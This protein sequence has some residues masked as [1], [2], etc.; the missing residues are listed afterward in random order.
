MLGSC[1]VSWEQDAKA[2]A[3]YAVGFLPLPDFDVYGKAGAAR[4]ELNHSV[5]YYN[6]GG[7]PTG[8]YAHSDH[9][10]VFTWGV[11]VQAHFGVIGGRLE[12]EGFNT[13][14]SVYSLSVFLNLK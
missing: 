11:G 4:Y 9:S 6:S 2:F 8:S 10:T 13:S 5:T 7:V 3:G 12:Y 1:A 14:T